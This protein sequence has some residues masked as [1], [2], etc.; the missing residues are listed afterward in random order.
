MFQKCSLLDTQN[1]LAKMWRTQPLNYKVGKWFYCLQCWMF[2][3]EKKLSYFLNVVFFCFS[4]L[5]RKV[6]SSYFFLM[7]ILCNF[8][9]SIP[10]YESTKRWAVWHF[11]YVG[12]TTKIL[13]MLTILSA[14]IIVFYWVMGIWGGVIL[15]IQTFFKAKNNAKSYID[16]HQ[17][18]VKV[19]WLVVCTKSM[20]IK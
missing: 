11:T 18:K 4:S 14:I 12:H 5:N 10:K 9:K 3:S 1:K 15:T 8:N 13:Q 19:T 16:E 17:L 2:I 6:L 7:F 20:K